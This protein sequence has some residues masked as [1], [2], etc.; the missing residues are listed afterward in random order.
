MLP[1]TGPRRAVRFCIGRLIT[2]TISVPPQEMSLELNDCL[3]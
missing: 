1:I 3:S 2:L